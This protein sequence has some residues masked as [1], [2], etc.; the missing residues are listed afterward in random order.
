MQTYLL[1]EWVQDRGLL[2]REQ[3]VRRLTSEPAAFFRMAGKGRITPGFDADLVLFDPDTIKPCD[4]EWVND[5][6]GGKQRLIERSEGIAYPI[7][8]GWE[9]LDHDQHHGLQPGQ[10]MADG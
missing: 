9:V 8:G 2:T 6:P 5:L 3:A 7:I 4:E 1:R 10:I